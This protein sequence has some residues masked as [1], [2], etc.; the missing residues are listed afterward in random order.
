MKNSIGHHKINS[1]ADI[2]T[3]DE[4][5]K[6]LVLLSLI[7]YKKVVYIIILHHRVISLTSTALSGCII[8]SIIWGY[9]KY[10]IKTIKRISEIW[11]FFS[12]KLSSVLVVLKG[13]ALMNYTAC[14][15]WIWKF[16]YYA[17]R[18]TNTNLNKGLVLA[19]LRNWCWKEICMRL[20]L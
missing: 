2:N 20:Y 7:R 14:E 18:I 8:L 5:F 3:S 16:D 10:Y 9:S 17:E 19:H 12:L 6:N 11:S 1:Q 4:N 15:S 13:K